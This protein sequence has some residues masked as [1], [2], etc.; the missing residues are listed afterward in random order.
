MREK[1]AEEGQD[2]DVALCST[3]DDA[4]L[5]WGRLSLAIPRREFVRLAAMMGRAAAELERRPSRRDATAGPA[6]RVLQ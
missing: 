4:H 5:R 3:C 6:S 2:G 1:L